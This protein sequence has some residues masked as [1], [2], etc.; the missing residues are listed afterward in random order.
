MHHCGVEEN[1]CPEASLRTDCREGSGPAHGNS[2][3][4]TLSC[5]T[6]SYL[7]CPERE[8]KENRAC[9]IWKSAPK[10]FLFLGC[11]F[12]NVEFAHICHLPTIL[13]CPLSDCF[14]SWSLT[15][16]IQEIEMIIFPET[17]GWV[18]LRLEMRLEC[19]STFTHHSLSG[20]PCWEPQ[21]RVVPGSQH[22]CSRS[23]ELGSFLQNR[24]SLS[25][26]N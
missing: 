20:E 13:T 25:L 15:L 19:G 7:R 12:R 21:R 6:H 16:I 9:E 18:M 5:N 17:R 2:F 8:R 23:R 26:T 10:K 1:I 14:V 24:N 3:S 11:D 4:A 22:L